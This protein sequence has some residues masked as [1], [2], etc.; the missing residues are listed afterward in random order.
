[1]QVFGHCRFSWFGVSDTGHELSTL[2]DAAARLWHPLRMAIRFHLFENLMLPSLSA[3]TDKDFILLVSVSDEMPAIFHARLEAAVAESPFVR[4][5]RTR[6]RDYSRMIKP[7]M[8][9]TTAG[10]TERSVH[11][12]LDDDDA[13]PAGYIARLRRDADR[14]DTGGVI[15]YPKGIVGYLEGDRARHGFRLISYHAQGLARVAGP[16]M[17]HSP[18]RMQHRE[19]GN[20]VPSY[21]DPTFVGFHF[22]L[23]GVNSTKGFASPVHE[24]GVDRRTSERMKRLNPELVEGADAPKECDVE[25]ANGFPYTDGPGIRAILEATTDPA[26]LCEAF[27]FPTE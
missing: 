15:C 27:G 11:F 10:G 22:T 13:L 23:H 2:E 21:V 1:M 26:R 19:I 16:G 3:Q 12:R 4:L 6:S 9:E 7:F 14:V 17:L 20:R 18:I 8:L 5:N 25:L 24:A